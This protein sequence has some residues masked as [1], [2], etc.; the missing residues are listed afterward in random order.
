[1]LHG[2]RKTNG[3]KGIFSKIKTKHQI[4]NWTKSIVISICSVNSVVAFYE[5][6]ASPKN[7]KGRKG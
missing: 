5:N 3:S 6:F 2:V 1:M 4:Y 7:C